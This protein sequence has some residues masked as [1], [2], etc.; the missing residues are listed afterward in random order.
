MKK[1]GGFRAIV[2]AVIFAVLAALGSR[3]EAQSEFARG[4]R[5]PYD[6][7]DKLAKT[8]LDVPGGVIHAAFAPGDIALPKGKILEWVR[9]SAKAVATYY[10]RS[11]VRACAVAPP[12]AIAARRSVC[13]WAASPARPT[14]GKTG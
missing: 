7:F 9:T 4:N 8:D 12:G 2:P 5:M 1:V 6:A 3:A 10:G 13:C 11:P 14:C